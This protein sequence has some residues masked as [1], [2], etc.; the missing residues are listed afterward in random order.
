[1]DTSE[2]EHLEALLRAFDE[3]LDYHERAGN[4]DTPTVMELRA[5]RAQLCGRLP[6][7]API[8]VPIHV[9]PSRR[10]SSLLS[11]SDE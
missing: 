8:D 6:N 2:T 5:K 1:M 7:D 3:V 10:R 9:D 11:P 4:R